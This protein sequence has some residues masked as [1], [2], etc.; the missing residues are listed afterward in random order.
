MS[1][2]QCVVIKVYLLLLSPVYTTTSR[3]KIYCSVMLMCMLII[4]TTLRISTTLCS[5]IMPTCLY[6]N[7]KILQYFDVQKEIAGHT[8]KNEM[9]HS[10]RIS[11]DTSTDKTRLIT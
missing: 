5:I 2:Y 1:I 11:H 7:R 6:S 9:S 8:I 3:I 10:S 4:P